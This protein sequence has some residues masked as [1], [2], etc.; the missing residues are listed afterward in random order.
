M[1]SAEAMSEPDWLCQQEMSV[2]EK[3][4][5]KRAGIKGQKGMGLSQSGG[6]WKGRHFWF[7]LA[8]LCR[9]P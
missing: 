4:V 5:Q 7:D 6:M 3:P 8:S 1:E 9:I 2:E